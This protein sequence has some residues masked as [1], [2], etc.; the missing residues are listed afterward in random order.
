MI[1]PALFEITV[2]NFASMLRRAC[3]KFSGMPHRPKPPTRILEPS[4]ISCK[5]S[6]AE[7]KI[8]TFFFSEY[9]RVF[10]ICKIFYLLR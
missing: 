10:N 3:I 1:L 8:L 9:S 5:A 4:L 2:N 6:A 7:L